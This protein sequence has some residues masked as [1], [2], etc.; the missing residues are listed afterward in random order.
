[1]ML[2]ALW[3]PSSS[4]RGFSFSSHWKLMPNALLSAPLLLWG[5]LLQVLLQTDAKC[6]PGCPPPLLVGSSS[7]L[8]H[9]L[10][11]TDAKFSSGYP[12][13]LVVDSHSVIG[14]WCKMLSAAL[15]VLWWFLIQFLLETD[16]DFPPLVVVSYSIL[17]EIW[18]KMLFWLLSSS[19]GGFLTILAQLLLKA[20]AKSS[21]GYLPPLVVDSHSTL[22]EKWC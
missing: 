10:L 9:F 19:C 17:I 11:K 22:I 12:S 16:A 5:F 1:M 20:G 7:I 3:L 15:L 13:P 21:S 18:W 8:S 2:N 14:R 6:S 4:C